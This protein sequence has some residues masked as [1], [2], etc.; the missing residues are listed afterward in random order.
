MVLN[1]SFMQLAMFL[2]WKTKDVMRKVLVS[3]ATKARQEIP[4]GVFTKRTY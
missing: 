4:P 1:Q 2:R 3:L